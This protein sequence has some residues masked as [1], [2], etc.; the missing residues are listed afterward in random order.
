MTDL[1]EHV[2]A[3]DRLVA[4][5]ST[6]DGP[7]VVVSLSRR[8]PAEMTQVWAALTEPDRVRRWFL[9]LTGDLRPGGTFQ[10]EGNASGDILTCRPAEQLV[11][12][13][14][15][16][17]SVVEVRLTADGG[18]TRLSLHHTVPMEMAGSSAGALYVGPGWD[19][20]LMGLALYLAGDVSRNPLE[21]S[22]S[23]EGQQFAAYS[24]DAWVAV[25]EASG[26]ADATAV[27]AAKKTSLAQFA[28][29]LAH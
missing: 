16:P 17:S 3:I 29:D 13:F 1:A 10:L 18:G 12:T 27:A 22:S 4:Q 9:V 24:L 19:A 11:I 2:D 6:G 8:Y 28:P 21:A 14:G 20:A 15:G 7:T 23:R 26:T 25:V 5:Q